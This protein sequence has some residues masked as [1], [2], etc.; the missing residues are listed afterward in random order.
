MSSTGP[1]LVHSD[2]IHDA[3]LLTRLPLESRLYIWP[4]LVAYVGWILGASVHTMMSGGFNELLLIP[5]ALVALGHFLCAMSIFWSVHADAW[6]GF[7]V[8]KS[9]ED[10]EWICVIPKEHC[11]R[12]GIVKLEANGERIMFKFHEEAFYWDSDK[13]TFSRPLYPD[14][15]PFSYYRRARGL[16]NEAEITEAQKIYGANR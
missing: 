12:P 4:F 8:Q 3:L 9:I 13:K 14:Q 11:G 16:A 15:F 7:K 1:R 5:L 2:R 6:L 10:A